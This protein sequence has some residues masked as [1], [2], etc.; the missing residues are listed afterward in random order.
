MIPKRHAFENFLL[1]K[2]LK[3]EVLISYRYPRRPQN[4]EVHDVSS[5]S[6][7][8]TWDRPFDG[9]SPITQYTVMWRRTDG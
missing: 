4:L 3:I 2:T 8:L 6:I 1:E 7:R 9:N 5:R